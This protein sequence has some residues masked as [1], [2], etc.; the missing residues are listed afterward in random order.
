[1]GAGVVMF[2]VGTWTVTHYPD[3]GIPLL[4]GGYLAVT[5]GGSD[6]DNR[7]GQ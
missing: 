6:G 2:A 3:L 7:V 5:W 1:M 4:I